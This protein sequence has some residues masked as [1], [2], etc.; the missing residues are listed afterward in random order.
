MNTIREIIILD[1]LARAAV[2]TVANGYNTGIGANVIR[3]R[4]KLDPDELPGTVVIPGPEKS[5]AKYGQNACKMIMRVE[6]IVDFGTSD[7]SVV[8]EQ[9]L[10][11]LKKCF[12]DPANQLTSPVSGWSRSPDYIDSIVY[13]EGGTQE[14]P[15]EGQVT[16]GAFV[17]FEVGYTTKLNDPYSQ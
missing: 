16:V 1:Y 11:D 9:I 7:P 12:L 2:I 15:D 3:A 10:G 8:S 4:K 14:Y 13:T 5:E 17:T 6:G